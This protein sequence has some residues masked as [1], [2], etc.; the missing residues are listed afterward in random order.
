MALI[1]RW[2][3]RAWCRVNPAR[4]KRLPDLV[5]SLC[6]LDLTRFQR[7][8][9]VREDGLLTVTCEYGNLL[10]IDVSDR[11]ERTVRFGAQGTA[12]VEWKSAA[13][14]VAHPDDVSH[15][16]VLVGVF[17]HLSRSIPPRPHDPSESFRRHGLQ[18]MDAV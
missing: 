15:R 13:I 16:L 17:G 2:M 14:K 10:E 18:R 4:A 6:H 9:F 5:N 7:L 1:G 3:R 8:R 12:R 11:L